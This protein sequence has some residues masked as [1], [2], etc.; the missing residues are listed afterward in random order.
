MLRLLSWKFYRRPLVLISFI[1]YL[2]LSRRDQS[3]L[4]A[5]DCPCRMTGCPRR[6]MNELHTGCIPVRA[7]DS[8]AIMYQYKFILAWFY[9]VPPFQ[10][11]MDT[12]ELL[13]QGQAGLRLFGC[14]RRYCYSP[15]MAQ[16]PIVGQDLLNTEALRSHSDTPHSVEL[17]WTND[18]PTAQTSTWQHT[19]DTRNRHPRRRRDSNPQTQ[20]ANGRRSTP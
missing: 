19:T 1:N 11:F 16:Q 3:W 20:Q 4:L 18:W 12:I 14:Q 17:L 15:P 2:F 6:Y 7:S 8:Y 5:V 13:V 10:V 9:T